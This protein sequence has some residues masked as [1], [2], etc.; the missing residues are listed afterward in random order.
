MLKNNAKLNQNE[1]NCVVGGTVAEFIEIMDAVAGSR[2]ALDGVPSALCSVLDMLGPAGMIG[3]SAVIAAAATP[4]EK[5]L[6][7]DLNIDAYIS[8][9]WAGTGFRSTHNRY[10][11]NGKSISHQEVLDMIRA[12]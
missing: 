6:K 4:L 3:K 11:I 5:A 9:G 10:S 1:L 2:K 12:A 7:K 8:V